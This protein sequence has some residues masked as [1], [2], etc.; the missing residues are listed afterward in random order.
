VNAVGH[1]VARFAGARLDSVAALGLRGVARYVLELI[2]VG[3]SYFALAKL[4]AAFSSFHPGMISLPAGLALAAVLLCGLRVWPAILIAALAAN[5]PFDDAMSTGPLLIAAAIAAGSMI[6]AVVGG[7]VI[8]VWSDGRRTFDT[9]AGVA[10]FALVTLGLSAPIG[11]TIAAGGL[12]FAGHV[13]SP[14]VPAL[15]AIWWLRDAPGAG[16]RAL[17]VARRTSVQA[18]HGIQYRNG[19]DRGGRGRAGRLQP[20]HRTNRQPERV[21]VPRRPA[22][23]VVGVALRP[24]RHRDGRADPLRLRHLGHGCRRRCLRRRGRK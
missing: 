23:G 11:A 3:T 2:V 10:K 15:W 22:A 4:G 18:G 19:A 6:E 1:A 12:S 8:K 5:L 13:A 21:G 20:D 14:N 16:D 7:V 24:A 17:G 9:A